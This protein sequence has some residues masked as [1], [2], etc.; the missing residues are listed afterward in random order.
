MFLNLSD[1]AL[2]GVKGLGK[3]WAAR[4]AAKAGGET[5]EFA[6]KYADDIIE[7]VLKQS[8]NTLRFSEKFQKELISNISEAQLGMDRLLNKI[9][10]WAA[11]NPVSASN[12]DDFISSIQKLKLTM[13]QNPRE[14]L[15]MLNNPE[16]I[17]VSGFPEFISLERIL[18]G[19]VK[20]ADDVLAAQSKYLGNNA[21]F[22]EEYIELLNPSNALKL[23]MWSK[24]IKNVDKLYSLTGTGKYKEIINKMIS[25]GNVPFMSK[26]RGLTMADKAKRIGVGYSAL[27]AATAAGAYGVYEWF[28]DNDPMQIAAKGNTVSS[29]LSGMSGNTINQINKS[30]ANVGAIASNANSGMATNPGAASQNY[31]RDMGREVQFLTNALK[32]WDAVV[33]EASNPE[34][35]IKARNNL[36]DLI[37]DVNN[38]MVDLGN[39]IGVNISNQGVA[40]IGP[41]KITQNLTMTENQN[42][43]RIQGILKSTFPGIKQTGEL[44][45]QTIMALKQL[46]S[47]FNARAGTNEFTGLFVV[48]E[49]GYIIKYDNL[50]ESMNIIRKY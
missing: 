33:A 6:T 40:G 26:I 48:P 28:D 46:E 3:L 34:E 35:A 45:T 8:D 30:I 21:K 5:A 14:A 22:I 50:I 42:I 36:V 4:G 37:Q 12:A 13:G 7:Q 11:N 18:S 39:K 2:K 31:I 47:S 29:A 17:A 44:D 16:F 25:D 20:N 32:N 41:S 49:T 9:K 1:E 23:E 38:S 19:V 43:T 10:I 15:A 24:N 27:S